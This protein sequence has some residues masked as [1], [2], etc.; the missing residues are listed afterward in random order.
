MCICESKVE[1]ARLRA[2]VEHGTAAR[3]LLELEP[4]EAMEYRRETDHRHGDKIARPMA[5]RVSFAE[6]ARIAQTDLELHEE[7]FRNVISRTG[8]ECMQSERSIGKHPVA[9]VATAVAG[10][11]L[12]ALEILARDDEEEM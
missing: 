9:M 5:E 8:S 4:N 7:Q 2:R 10:C 1:T 3:A 11:G 6:P 12:L